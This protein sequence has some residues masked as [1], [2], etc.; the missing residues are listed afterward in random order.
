M[1]TIHLTTVKDESGEE[2]EVH[3]DPSKLRNAP[4]PKRASGSFMPGHGSAFSLV[5]KPAPRAAA[6]PRDNAEAH[7]RPRVTDQVGPAGH[8]ASDGEYLAIKKEALVDLISI[9]G[10]AWAS[11]LARPDIPQATG[12]VKIDMENAS[13]HRDALALHDQNRDRI[14]V[15]SGLAERAA[16]LLFS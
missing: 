11:F 13:L 5:R 6:A 15:L 16:R 7:Q 3:L 14:R 12:D 8:V 9:A 4:Q 1:D 2:V 10:D